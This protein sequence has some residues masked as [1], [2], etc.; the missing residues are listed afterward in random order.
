M[1]EV[2]VRNIALGENSLHN[3][4]FLARDFEMAF[5]FRFKPFVGE[6]GLV[7]RA[8][9]QNH[10]LALVV[11]NRALF[12]VENYSLY[13][14]ATHSESTSL[15]ELQPDRRYSLRLL[16]MGGEI[17][18]S[19]DGQIVLS[20]TLPSANIGNLYIWGALTGRVNFY[21]I[22]AVS[23]DRQQDLGQPCFSDQFLGLDNWEVLNGN[24]SSG[25]G[26]L[27]GR[28]DD[29]NIYLKLLREVPLSGGVSFYLKNENDLR[30]N[31]GCGIML[32]YSRKTQQGV[33]VH[34][35][36]SHGYVSFYP[37][38]DLA[39]YTAGKEICYPGLELKYHLLLKPNCWHF[40]QIRYNH[41]QM[42]VYFD[43]LLIHQSNNVPQ[44]DGDLLLCVGEH[45]TARFADFRV[46]RADP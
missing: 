26:A 46:F 11:R 20:R 3:L 41:S 4:G 23:L 31:Y 28:A 25:S 43:E 27:L 7:F 2:K 45:N 22:H 8:A 37:D 36:P 16:V 15:K 29:R 39:V 24:W 10:G 6:A 21:R 19:V 1:K 33:G 44:S 40:L 30:L 5:H 13:R 42:W 9:D 38:F 17:K 34:C 18:V 32:R 35:F 14:L 12:F